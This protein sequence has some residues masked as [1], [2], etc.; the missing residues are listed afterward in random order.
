MSGGME[1]SGHLDCDAIPWP[2]ILE[3][4]NITI[5]PLNAGNSKRRLVLPA[6]PPSRSLEHFRGGRGV[7]AVQIEPLP[8]TAQASRVIEEKTIYAG[9]LFRH[10]GHVVAESIH[11]LWPRLAFGDLRRAK[12]AF[13]PVNHA[14]IMPYFR[15]A[16]ALHGIPRIDVV[17]IDEPTC[18]RRLFIGPQARQMAGPTIIPFYRTMLDDELAKRL[19]PAGGNR[20][21]YLS[22][23]QHSH[24]GSFYGESYVE[25]VLTGENFEIVYPEQHSITDLVTMLRA[26]SVAVF[27]EGSAI[28]ALELC[29]SAIPDTFVIG[30]R[31]GSAKRFTPLLS[32]ISDRWMIS[33]QLLLNSGMSHNPKK[34]SGVLDMAALMSD[35]QSFLGIGS[36]KLSSTDIAASVQNDI[37]E[38]IRDPRNKRDDGYELRANELRRAAERAA[39]RCQVVPPG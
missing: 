12:I 4:E 22:R 34:H 29:G 11:R 38:H 33:D 6:D 15:Q 18:F 7:S 9:L 27:A 23:R 28:H 25:Q 31:K 16:L 5:G 37:E 10:F 26:S 35:L 24:T 2:G 21:L 13:S 30:R 39:D 20:R 14:K 17:R 32:N 3:V 8:L 1:A 36:D 19:P